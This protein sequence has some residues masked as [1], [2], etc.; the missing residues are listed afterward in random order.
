MLVNACHCKQHIFFVF[1]GG[2][3]IIESKPARKE[4]ASTEKRGAGPAVAR[5]LSLVL[6][7]MLGRGTQGDNSPASLALAGLVRTWLGIL[8]YW[9]LLQ[10]ACVNTC[11]R[12]AA[13]PPSP[14]P[15]GGA[16]GRPCHPPR[17]DDEAPGA[18]LYRR[19]PPPPAGQLMPAPQLQPRGGQIA[20][21]SERATH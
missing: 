13:P 8:Q 14:G 10:F 5:A 16:G 9:I 19:S 20:W 1:F 11:V 21:A 18:Y 7:G 15:A 3:I 12:L 17:A 4:S 6:R 2:G